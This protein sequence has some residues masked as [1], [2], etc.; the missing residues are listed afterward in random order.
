VS[1]VAGA[2][3]RQ[4]EV[5]RMFGVLDP[6]LAARSASMALAGSDYAHVRHFAN[7]AEQ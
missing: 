2:F 1:D 5:Q 7:A 3:E 4:N 6:A